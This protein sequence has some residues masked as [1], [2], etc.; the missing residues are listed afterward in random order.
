MC[1]AEVRRTLDSKT[2]LVS[3]GS[4]ARRPGDH[5][6]ILLTHH[7]VFDGW[8]QAHGAPGAGY[9]VLGVLPAQGKPLPP[10]PLQF[11]D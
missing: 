7:M 9:P 5:V 3:G 1:Q 8:R 2:I 6:L 11:A 4:A 10:L